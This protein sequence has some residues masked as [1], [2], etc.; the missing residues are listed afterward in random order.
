MFSNKPATCHCFM[1]LQSSFTVAD[2]C[3]ASTAPANGTV[4]TCT[5]DLASG[6]TC[7]PTCNP[8]YNVSGTSNCTTGTLTAATCNGKGALNMSKS[9]GKKKR[10]LIL[11]WNFPIHATLNCSFSNCF[12]RSYELLFGGSKVLIMSSD[13]Q[14]MNPQLFLN[15]E[16][17]PF[18]V[19]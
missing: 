2:P 19:A 3:D 1:P 10:F 16:N 11:H 14:S 6:S 15:L 8:G 18:K 9:T 5:A 17:E 4:G 7:Q 13:P 12:R